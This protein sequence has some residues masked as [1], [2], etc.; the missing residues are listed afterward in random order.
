MRQLVI[1]TAV[2]LVVG[3]TPANAQEADPNGAPSRLRLQVL[4]AFPSETF[5]THEETDRIAGP[6]RF[7]LAERLSGNANEWLAL[8]GQPAPAS[9]S[10]SRF[11]GPLLWTLVIIAATTVGFIVL[12]QSLSP[13]KSITPPD[14]QATAAGASPQAFRTSQASV[15]TFGW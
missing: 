6:E 8:A 7:R 14:T 15:F 5:V 2:A 1:A 11:G 3:T 10:G 12:G 4:A 13:G 9:G